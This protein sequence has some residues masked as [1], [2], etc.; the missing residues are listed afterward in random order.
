VLLGPDLNEPQREGERLPFR[1]VR[2]P[3]NRSC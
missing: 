3:G 1:L 2:G